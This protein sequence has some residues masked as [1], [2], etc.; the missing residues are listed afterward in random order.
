MKQKIRFAIIISVCLIL[1]AGVFLFLYI[2]TDHARSMVLN[3]INS[4]IPGKADLDG[5]KF[6][7]TGT[8]LQM[9]GLTLFDRNGKECIKARS[10]FIDIRLSSLFKKSIDIIEFRLEDPKILMIRDA[11][12]CINL[13]QAVASEGCG[14][15]ER[16]EAGGKKAGLPFNIAVEKAAIHNGYFSLTDPKNKVTIG[17]ISMD[18]TRADFEKKLLALNTRIRKTELLVNLNPLLIQDLHVQTD[19]KPGG[20]LTFFTELTSDVLNLTGSGSV[21]QLFGLPE[22]DLN[23][24]GKGK[25]ESLSPFLDHQTRL[26]GAADLSFSGKG[27]VSSPE[28]KAGIEVSN[29]GMN[30][31]IE[32]GNIQLAFSL[33]DRSLNIDSGQADLFGARLSLKGSADFAPLFP[34]GFLKPP[35]RS[36]QAAYS[37]SFEQKNGDLLKLNRWIQGFSGQFSSHGKIDGRG[38]DPDTLSVNSRISF[39]LKN[40]K[41]DAAQAQAIDIAAEFAGSM[42]NGIVT[43]APLTIEAGDS[44]ISA[45]GSF[46]VK[47]RKIMAG[48]NINAP[49]LGRVTGPFGIEPLKGSVTSKMNLSGQVTAPDI[50][51][52]IEVRNLSAQGQD[53]PDAEFE[54]GLAPSGTARIDKLIV[55]DEALLCDIS[56]SADLFDPGFKL[57]Q[58]IR[59]SLSAKGENI[60]PGALMKK[61]NLMEDPT[62]FDSKVNFN[63]N[64]ETELPSDPDAVQ[65]Q[66][67]DVNIPEIILTAGID[68]TRKTIDARIGDI[69]SLHT[70]L[71]LDRHPDKNRF[72]G[73]IVFPQSSFSPILDSLGMPG[74][75]LLV[76][77]KIEAQGQLPDSLPPGVIKT[78]RTFQGNIDL[79]ASL[80]GSTKK[81][82]Y[83]AGLLLRN[84]NGDIGPELVPGG[85]RLA[86][87]NGKIAAW[88][89]R[90]LIDTIQAGINDGRLEVSGQALMA[91][92]QVKSA[93]LKLEAD[94]LP[95]PVAVR[96]QKPF[97]INKLTADL[98]MAAAYEKTPD[99]ET[100]KTDLS[101]RPIPFQKVLAD[102]DLA[103]PSIRIKLDQ[104]ITLSASVQPKSGDYQIE[105]GFEKTS[106]SPYL[107]MIGITGIHPD[108]NGRISS[109]GSL[110]GMLPVEILG[111]LEKSA[112]SISLDSSIS[113]TLQQPVFD[114]QI[115]LSGI[116]YDFPQAGTDI[117][118]LSGA[119]LAT[120]D[121]L[122]IQKIAGSMGSGNFSL[123][124]AVDL[125]NFQ[126]VKGGI[127][128]VS[129]DIEIEIPDMAETAF[130]TDLNFKA[131]RETS[132]LSG[133]IQLIKGEYYKDFTFDLTG[134]MGEKKRTTPISDIEKGE[135]NPFIDRTRLNIDVTYKD[136][137]TVDNNLIFALI[138]PDVTVTGTAANPIVTGRAEIIEGTVS[139][140]KREFEIE[141]G[142]I[143]FIDPYKTDPDIDLA[144]K[145]Q[146]RDWLVRL[147]IKGKT[148]NLSFKLYSDPQESHEDILSLLV[149][150]KTTKE[151]RQKGGSYT[152][153]L[154][155]KASDII[156]K[157]VEE[158]T[159]LDSFKIGYDGSGGQGSNVSVTMGKKLSRRLQVTYTMKTEEE[160]TVHTNAAEY[161]L[162]ENLMLKAFNDSKGD[163]GTEFKFKLEFR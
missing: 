70:G 119:I 80:K 15:A 36:G 131:D 144:A 54:G 104:T 105:A 81:P 85:I 154:T 67:T 162:L 123:D 138:V 73:E 152:N 111:A 145:T 139:Y 29:F 38:I 43:A 153:V 35:N 11:Q 2:Q 78:M 76:E 37:F 45:D 122:E 42:E 20:Q 103:D 50:Y 129:T 44:S 159:P 66:N 68:L 89:E 88:P 156:G 56:G 19:L 55:K 93:S 16:K 91:D 47:N 130:N 108:L 52:R 151:L 69:L 49:D 86:G 33:E 98:D 1:M 147:E 128:F 8:S 71:D 32:Q 7:L 21:R 136:P 157:T 9:E 72:A 133:T 27:P 100:R 120:Q 126:P 57:K 113:G 26:K 64:L 84:I 149:S 34:D 65:W 102:I 61:F 13:L 12:G 95:V 24:S 137:F 74:V 87:L 155:D 135:G 53:L 142:I 39:S 62:P 30:E 17:D 63:L 94:H 146:I 23:F 141:R 58:K 10:L 114:S 83:T 3:R 158:S 134:A 28:I 6:S 14:P 97:E 161:K 101:G 125:E 51:G 46:D 4:I 59:A 92:Y 31:D 121:R 132:D 106:L 109:Q 148:D 22:I 117:S 118:G 96:N 5:V 18:L 116:Q 60:N 48:L 107:N 82:D 25:L 140:Q 90:I 41:Q 150:G 124:G 127:R 77:G 115:R 112:G 40:F 75:K 110:S 160:E 163:F 143:D 79:N 99:S